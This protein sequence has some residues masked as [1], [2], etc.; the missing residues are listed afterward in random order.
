MSVSEEQGMI[1]I[2][3]VENQEKSKMFY[4]ELL[5][6]KPALH[7]PGMT[8]FQLS[9]STKLGIMPE[10]GIMRVLESKIPNPNKASGIPRCEIYIFVDDPGEYYR[11]LINAGGVGI[12]KGE[13]RN[14]GDYVAY[15]LDLD[16]HVLAFARKI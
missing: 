1:M 15:G 16:G 13:L 7:V 5:G 12:S 4:E 2:I 6:I 10:E 14:W 9:S 8:E 11:R 3:Y